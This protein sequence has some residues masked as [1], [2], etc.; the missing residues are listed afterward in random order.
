MERVISLELAALWGAGH[1]ERVDGKGYPEMLS[2]TEINTEAGI[3]SLADAYVA[4]V[5]S[6]PCC[7]PLPPDDAR[8][9]PV[10]GAGTQWD[11]FLGKGLLEIVRHEADDAVPVATTA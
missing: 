10:A 3:L 9:I 1:H 8:A 7:E 4:M 6:R 11:P 5:S 2:G